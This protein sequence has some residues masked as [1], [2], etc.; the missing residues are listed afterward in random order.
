MLDNIDAEKLDM[1]IITEKLMSLATDA[2]SDSVKTKT[3][4]VSIDLP[5]QVI[6]VMEYISKETEVS[7]DSLYSKMASVNLQNEINRIVESFGMKSEILEKEKKPQDTEQVEDFTQKFEQLTDVLSTFKN[8]AST[9]EGIDLQGI[10]E[11][12]CK[13]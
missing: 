8:L 2:L 9:L 13:K 12:S 7:L 11:T 6:D 4:V 10:N 1:K 5:T 3:I